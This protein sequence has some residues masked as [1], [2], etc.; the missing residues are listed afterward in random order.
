MAFNYFQNEKTEQFECV[1]SMIKTVWYNPELKRMRVQFN[2]DKIYEYKKIP[3]KYWKR[4]KISK[5]AGKFFNKY[6]KENYKGQLIDKD[7]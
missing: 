7:S 2:N 4:L 1:S 5:S 3:K 6:I